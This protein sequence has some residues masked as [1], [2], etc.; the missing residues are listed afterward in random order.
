[1]RGLIG[2]QT[3]AV[4]FTGRLQYDEKVILGGGGFGRLVLITGRAD[5]AIPLGGLNADGTLDEGF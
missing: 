5:H 4:D 1:M 3:D 2:S